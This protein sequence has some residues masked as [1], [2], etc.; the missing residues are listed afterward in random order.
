MLAQYKASFRRERLVLCEHL[1]NKDAKMDDIARL[2]NINNTTVEYI[3]DIIGERNLTAAIFYLKKA[4][5]QTQCTGFMPIG[6]EAQAIAATYDIPPCVAAIILRYE[7]H[8]YDTLTRQQRV[9][10]LW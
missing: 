3:A 10:Y 8:N 9:Q 4:I 7:R 1:N 6:I 2:C 5:R